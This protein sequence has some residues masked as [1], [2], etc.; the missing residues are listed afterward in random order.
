[1]NSATTHKQFQMEKQKIYISFPVFYT[2]D[3]DK[4]FLISFIKNSIFS[5]NSLIE[6]TTQKNAQIEKHSLRAS[7]GSRTCVLFSRF[8]VA[9]TTCFPSR[10][11]WGTDKVTFRRVFE[12]SHQRI[13]LNHVLFFVLLHCVALLRQNKMHLES[14]FRRSVDSFL[15][16]HVSNI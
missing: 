6:G 4:I 13:F 14:R 1:M 15:H 8:V 9:K 16:L 12:Q 11:T 3:C 7:T 2:R 5:L 10:V